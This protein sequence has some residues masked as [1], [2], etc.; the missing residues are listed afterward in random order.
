MSHFDEDEPFWIMY[1][2]KE[3]I[4]SLR[5]LMIFLAEFPL[6]EVSELRIKLAQEKY[7]C[8]NVQALKILICENLRT[9]AMLLSGDAG[10][11]KTSQATAL[12][13]VF[14]VPLY[15]QECYKGI[16]GDKALYSFNEEIQKI[17]LDILFK[18]NPNP[19]EDELQKVLYSIG[20]IQWG[21]LGKAY[22]DDVEDCFILI[23]EIDKIPPE[24]GFEA[25]LLTYIDEFRFFIPELNITIQPKTKRNPLIMITS[26]AGTQHGGS[27][28]EKAGGGIKVLSYPLQRRGTHFHLSSP[29]ISRTYQIIRNTCPNLTDEVVRHIVLYVARLGFFR[30]SDDSSSRDLPIKMA[31]SRLEKPIGT[32]EIIDWAK[33]L[34]WLYEKYGDRLPRT[35][36]IPEF[37]A[38]TVERLAKTESDQNT[39]ITGLTDD[40][41]TIYSSEWDAEKALKLLEEEDRGVI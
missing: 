3:T 23:N 14:D 28:M 38:L 20:N 15:R 35:Q 11:G 32:S 39:L 4:Y 2:V 31:N 21:T 12:S 1:S 37:V 13:R 36:L 8:N 9:S 41:R 27:S 16:T 25:L 29:N 17:K 22:V 33:G 6:P 26:N 7:F 19:S 18:N 24:E 34:Q 40:I 30:R 10:A 5:E